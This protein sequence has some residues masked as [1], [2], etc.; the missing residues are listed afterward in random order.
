MTELENMQFS[1]WISNEGIAM[2]T[3]T[4]AERTE[5][6]QFWLNSQ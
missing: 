6:T 5:L 2:N 3:K 4:E 1:K